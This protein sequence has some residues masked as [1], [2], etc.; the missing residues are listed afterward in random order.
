MR[1]FRLGLLC[2]LLSALFSISLRGEEAGT[3]ERTETVFSAVITSDLH[4]SARRQEA[5]LIVPL[6]PHVEEAMRALAEEVIALQPDAFIATGDLTVSGK[7]ED[8]EALSGIM[9]EIHEAGIRVILT[10]G[11]HDFDS[12]KD[13]Y[14]RNYGFLSE[15]DLHDPN[16]LSVLTRIGGV[17]IFAMDDCTGG[18][19]MNAGFSA[20]TCEWLRENLERERA[21]G[22][23]ILF[24]AH[25]SV[26]LD[27]AVYPESYR[28]AN[29]ELPSILENAGA[30]LIFTGH[31]HNQKL[32]EKG[33]L[34]ELI[35]AMPWTGSYLIGRL[36][37]EGD[38]IL[39]QTEPIDFDRFGE[40]G[41][42]EIAE[43]AAKKAAETWREVPMS[44]GR[45]KGLSEGELRKAG[46]LFERV[47]SSYQDGVLPAHLEEIRE[48]ESLDLLR[49]LI[50][51]TNYG[52]WFEDL[53]ANS[54]TDASSLS[55]QW[56]K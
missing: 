11:N 32:L 2:A 41:L 38:S 10:P 13:S 14:G 54:G 55:F 8:A 27:R 50:R 40:E 30:Q 37:I 46:D 15:G 4:Y 29:P 22:Q 49:E 35:S 47:I 39:Y 1:H 53:L 56:G 42:S 21:S 33:I 24:L 28:I 5:G 26:L 52:P 6:L 17:S 51:E 9:R 7:E 36:S 43:E 44:L 19:G 45:E 3:S 20:S 18:S 48:N 12:D 31:M 25:R 16:S 34:H 23:K